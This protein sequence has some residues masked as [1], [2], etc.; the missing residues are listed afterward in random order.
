MKELDFD[1]KEVSGS[2]HAL[3]ILV[4]GEN[5]LFRFTHVVPVR[6]KHQLQ[7]INF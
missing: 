1:F 7:H 2:N 3:K 6:K 4:E 5:L